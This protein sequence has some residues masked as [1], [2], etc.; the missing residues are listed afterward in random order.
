MRIK[1]MMWLC[2]VVF[3][4]PASA[5]GQAPCSDLSWTPGRHG[6]FGPSAVIVTDTQ[7]FALG[8]SG[9]GTS[10][11]PWA[12]EDSRSLA[13]SSAR[14]L[15]RATFLEAMGWGLLG[16]A[17]I[18]HGLNPRTSD[19]RRWGLLIAAGAVEI[20]G[21]HW[22]NRGMRRLKAAVDQHN[23]SCK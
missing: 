20:A 18:D 7:R 17:V 4:A 15:R 23:L 12:D 3:T 8:P 19:D 10:R 1:G 22:R 14:R 16:A 9:S 2:A 11:V 21:F 5:G 13:S 6:I